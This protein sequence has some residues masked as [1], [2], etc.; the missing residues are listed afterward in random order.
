MN[1]KQL[2]DLGVP[3]DVADQIIVLH[4][5]DIEKHKTKIEDY[6]T[7]LETAKSQMAEASKTIDSFKGLKIDEIQRAAD[8]WKAKAEK[9]QTDAG[10]QIK[11]VK[12]DHALADAL[13]SAKAKNPK[14]VRAL[15]NVDRLSYDEKEGSIVGLPEQLEKVRTEN[16]FL[17]EPTENQD[18]TPKI[19][20]KSQSRT[21]L[22][23]PVISAARKAAGLPD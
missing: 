6:E 5:K 19:V 12:F 14:A 8:D 11:Q 17:F 21:V 22:K 2:I 23:D 9:A 7:Q 16:D 10:L 13:S 18:P 4:G 20:T 3:E 1:K 15:L